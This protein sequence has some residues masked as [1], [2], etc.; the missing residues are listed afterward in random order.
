MCNSRIENLFAIDFVFNKEMVGD[1][2]SHVIIVVKD[3]FIVKIVD[4]SKID[5]FILVTGD[6]VEIYGAIKT[7]LYSH[8]IRV[9]GIELVKKGH[10]IFHAN[11]LVVIIVSEASQVNLE[12]PIKTTSYLN[13]DYYVDQD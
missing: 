5:D 12:Q 1:F 8:F 11:H 13:D 10:V 7:Q 6:V 2:I 4:D 9:R 3:S